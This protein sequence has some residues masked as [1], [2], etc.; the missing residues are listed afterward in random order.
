MEIIER[1]LGTI[2]PGW[3]LKRAHSRIRLSAT[4][5]YEGASKAKRMGGW[6]T[7]GGSANSEI[8]FSGIILRDRARDLYRNNPWARRAVNAIVDNTVGHGVAAQIAADSRETPDGKAF[9]EWWAEWAGTTACDANGQHDLAGLQR[10]WL[11]TIAQSGECLIRARLRRSSDGLP[12]PLQLQVLEP[13][14]I[15]STTTANAGDDR[16]VA[17]VKFNKIGKRLGYQLYKEHPG[18]A[19]SVSLESVFVPAE[20]VAHGYLQERPGQVRGVTWLAA[21][22]IRMR[23][24]D[25]YEDAELMRQKI[26]SC[27]AGYITD[28]DGEIGSGPGSEEVA[29]FDLVEPGTVTTL[30]PGV[31]IEFSKPP[32]VTG[33]GAFVSQQ[34]RAVAMSLGI[35]YQMLAGDYSDVNF[36]S[37]RMGHLEAQRTIGVWQRDVIQNQFCKPV[38][39]WAFQA[40]MIAGRQNRP[41]P[42]HW[43]PP[44]RE[45]IDPAK[46]IPALVLAIESGLM[47]WPAAV[48]SMGYDPEEQLATI[49]A[50]QEK[51][52]ALGIDLGK[53]SPGSSDRAGRAVEAIKEEEEESKK[54][55][56]SS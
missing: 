29:P 36:S 17:G 46:E 20:S 5:K 26:A 15:D 27:F 11:R 48:Q 10:L 52:K 14:H 56:K 6:K 39:R 9:S 35:T 21:A 22:I 55:S 18:E 44:R 1:A 41:I 33:Y 49:A 4:R 50:T 42:V 28:P 2:S 12:I 37:G 43:I 24:L 13:D 7:A 40:A 53:G 38:L 34:L 8:E 19:S 23:N 25:G 32:E 51:M 45:M 54:N 30:P 47:T 31:S 16:F 3:A